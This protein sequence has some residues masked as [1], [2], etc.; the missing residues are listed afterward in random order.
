MIL[1]D[2]LNK[3]I[4]EGLSKDQIINKLK[5]DGFDTKEIEAATIDLPTIPSLVLHNNETGNFAKAKP[6]DNNTKNILMGCLFLVLGI[7]R[8][9][10]VRGGGGNIN[11]I[12]GLLLSAYGGY[13]LVTALA[14]KN[15]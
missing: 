8:L 14:A 6:K 1:K 4:N 7:T 5:I 2:T 15:N 12:M 10:G 3:Y 13:R 11:L 9:A